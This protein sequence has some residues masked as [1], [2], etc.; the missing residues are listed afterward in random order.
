MA[1]KT[2]VSGVYLDTLEA[3]WLVEGNAFDSMGSGVFL[4][5]GRQN[6]VRSNRFSN[7]SS[8]PV[9]LDSVGLTMQCKDGQR[10]GCAGYYVRELESTFHFRQPPW[11]L[12]FPSI[13]IDLLNQANQSPP[14]E[15]R[16]LSINCIAQRLKQGVIVEHL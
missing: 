6:V 11:S 3:G 12:A 8:F 16:S 4:A 5:G 7:C 15:L 10:N 2:P 1:Q 9:Y 14:G 13:R